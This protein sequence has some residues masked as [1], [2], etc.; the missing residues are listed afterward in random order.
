MGLTMS[1]KMA[2][3]LKWVTGE[4][5]PGA[6]EDRLFAVAQAL[7]TA[8]D[9]VEGAHPLLVSGVRRV[10]EGVSGQADDAFVRSMQAYVNDSPGYLKS[11][12]R[13]LREV[14]E[15]VSTSG[16]QV[17]YTKIIIYMSV[18]ELLVEVTV[19]L[20]MAW[21]NPAAVLDWMAKRFFVFRLL[22]ETWLGRLILHIAINMGVGV[23]LQVLMDAIA[24]RMQIAM[25]T[26][27]KWDAS[28]TLQSA[29]VGALGGAISTILGPAAGALAD[30]AGKAVGKVVGKTAGEAV[31]AA[32]DHA[33]PSTPGLLSRETV[34]DVVVEIA[35]EAGGEYFTEGLYGVSQG[36]G[37]QV[38]GV[39]AVSG[40]VSGGLTSGVETGVHALKPGATHGPRDAAAPHGTPAHDAPAAAEPVHVPSPVPSSPV[41][42]SPGPMPADRPAAGPPSHALPPPSAPAGRLLDM[43]AEHLGGP[44][45]P[46]TAPTPV[47]AEP[48]SPTNSAS[49]RPTGTPVG[50]PHV[51]APAG[52][53]LL[54]PT[55]YDGARL[56]T[57]SPVDR[58]ADV[59]SVTPPPSVPGR[60]AAPPAGLSTDPAGTPSA[61][62]APG[63][64]PVVPSAGLGAGSVPATLSSNGL[65]SVPTSPAQTAGSSGPGHPTG[66]STVAQPPASPSPSGEVRMPASPSLPAPTVA[67]GP[68]AGSP[69]ASAPVEVAGASVDPSTRPPGTQPGLPPAAAHPSVSPSASTNMAAQSWVTPAAVTPSPTASPTVP[70]TT[71]APTTVMPS[72]VTTSP[73]APS[74]V[75]PAPIAPQPL[76]AGASPS[77]SVPPSGTSGAPSTQV[78][79]SG[80][81]GVPSTSGGSPAQPSPV[82][83]STVASSTAAPS[84]STSAVAPPPAAAPAQALT[85]DPVVPMRS[86]P[87]V[88]PGSSSS[89]PSGSTPPP[90]PTVVRPVATGP[91]VPVP[92]TAVRTET[93][94]TVAASAGVVA[95]GREPAAPARP[96]AGHTPVPVETPTAAQQNPQHVSASEA[97]TAHTANTAV[98]GDGAA[99]PSS[100]DA[101]STPGSPLDRRLSRRRARTGTGQGWLRHLYSGQ[102]TPRLVPQWFSATPVKIRSAEPPVGVDPIV[103]RDYSW[104]RQVN[105]QRGRTAESDTNCM[106]TA[107]ATD[108]ALADGA[109]YAA[110]PDT[111]S[112]AEHLERYRD[113]PPVPVPDLRSVVAVMSRAPLNSRGMVVVHQPDKMFAHVFN[114]VHDNNGVVFLDGQA[115][116]LAQLPNGPS[117]LFFLPTTDGILIDGPRW[118]Y[119]GSLGATHAPVE[120]ALL[121]PPTGSRT[122][123]MFGRPVSATGESAPDPSANSTGTTA[124][125]AVRSGVPS[126]RAF[127]VGACCAAGRASRQVEC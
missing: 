7:H 109:V 87:A 117:N 2:G 75:V 111:M 54:A 112:P 15:G 61:N 39:A 19:A 58:P 90:A 49:T 67:A 118:R 101:V 1:D 14:G 102:R 119:R 81:S 8:A 13:N 3:F 106:I 70:L 35:S 47:R 74:P 124:G 40:V 63:P 110:P 52:G 84:A 89:L 22:V 17:Q 121:D 85:S 95:A 107:I 23:G 45:R 62:A 88:P 33:V 94:A 86:T 65:A 21:I 51:S 103:L 36:V 113:R 59:R 41:L 4:D 93:G 73:N 25:G 24:Q 99:A 80:S 123:G 38:G 16:T 31:E 116:D 105:S 29:G 126:C 26:R 46:S 55:S 66:P 43:P 104:L 78:T 10:R 44:E 11:G 71:V 91:T 69:L 98:D 114:V 57:G 72:T 18:I 100:A 37:W 83:L 9:G 20:A 97:H 60:A 32:A 108:L 30:A 76:V 56:A 68:T 12:A 82:L 127:R 5:F 34:K 77:T 96:S 50:P 79:S 64:V 122:S 53:G 28:L 125:G 6:D 120:A 48:T 115:G 42:S 27:D 92:V